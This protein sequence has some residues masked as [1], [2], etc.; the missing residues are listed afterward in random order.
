MT[1][2]EIDREADKYN[3]DGRVW[4]SERD[5]IQ[6]L[7]DG[8]NSEV[9]NFLDGEPEITG[10]QAGH[11]AACCQKLAERMLWNLHRKTK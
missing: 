3:M 8:I 7:G 9:F 5:R 1:N 2:A 6:A 11:I 4:I 10:D